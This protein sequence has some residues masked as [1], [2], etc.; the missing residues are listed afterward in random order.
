MIQN[1]PSGV[2]TYFTSEHS[3]QVKHFSQRNIVNPQMTE[4]KVNERQE[5]VMSIITLMNTIYRQNIALTGFVL[6]T[7]RIIQTTTNDSI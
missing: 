7:L 6:N 2:E 4:H 3:E 5:L 1:F